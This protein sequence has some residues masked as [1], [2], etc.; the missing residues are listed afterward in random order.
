MAACPRFVEEQESCEFLV[1][2]AISGTASILLAKSVR[3]DY[4]MGQ[5]ID[6][7][8]QTLF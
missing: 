5:A 2:V 7:D 4:G 8:G 1:G 3:C 6:L